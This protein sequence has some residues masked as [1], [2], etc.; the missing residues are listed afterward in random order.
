[1]DYC[2]VIN[3][4]IDE[5]PK[6]LPKAWR[7]VSG[8]NK[9]TAAHLKTLGWLPVVYVNETYDPATQIRTGPVGCNIGDAVA[10]GADDVT[11]TYTVRAKTQTELDNEHEARRVEADDFY[12]SPAVSA[13]IDA[14]EDNVPTAQGKIRAEARL[15][16][17]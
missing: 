6:P 4:A 15:K 11:G 12:N 16:I 5:G 14:I 3:S 9:A 7:N 17:R 8:L 10:Q 1:M 2:H 13:L